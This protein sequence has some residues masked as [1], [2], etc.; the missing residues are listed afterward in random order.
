M[1]IE[2]AIKGMNNI[3]EHWTYRPSEAEA[4]KTAI[5]ALEKQIPKK[6]TDNGHCPECFSDNDCPYNEEKVRCCPSCG[7]K[8]DWS[9]EE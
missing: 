1:K 6:P 2:E 5:T 8:L 7:Q 9:D 3:I 4:A